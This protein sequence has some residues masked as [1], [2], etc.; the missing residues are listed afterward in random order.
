[1]KRT[2]LLFLVMVLLCLSP[3]ALANGW[4]LKGELLQLVSDTDD[5]NDYTT[6][7]DQA[8]NIAIMKSRYHHVLMMGEEGRLQTYTKA[9][10][11]PDS[12]NGAPLLTQNGATFSIRYH[13]HLWF[14]FAR[15][16][17]GV[18]HLHSAQS[19]EI[20]V[21]A[22]ESEYGYSAVDGNGTRARLVRRIR[23]EDFNIELFPRTINDVRHLNLMRDWLDSESPIN[24]PLEAEVTGAGEGTA[25]V[26]SAPFGKSAWRAA[27][28]K[29]AVGLGGRLWKMNP[30]RNAEGEE[31]W[32][33]RYDV[34]QRTQR[35]GYI[36]RRY[37]EAETWWE[38]KD[39][40][41]A[42]VEVIQ[43]TYLTDDPDV[44]QYRQF[45][46]PAGTQLTCLGLY[47]D[48]YAYVSAEAKDGRVVDGGQIVWGF[49][50]LRDIQ[51]MPAAR[52]MDVM[53]QLA[54]TWW[55]YAGGLQ[56]G[57]VITLNADGTYDSY[58]GVWDGELHG[59]H[60]SHGCWYVLE[61]NPSYGLYWNDP[62]YEI[63]FLRDDGSARVHGL[64]VDG[65]TFSL[66]FWEGGGGYERVK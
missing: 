56:E 6:L 8:G 35:I 42:A 9:V 33:I 47:N 31:Y 10:F 21:K 61:H 54:G 34:S 43:A 26:Y 5:W 25:P 22:T 63:V 58:L 29:A 65:D 3:A 39:Y 44:S 7:G 37:L 45:E 36:E 4:G 11:Q 64:T 46:L 51:M 66:T 41:H 18:Y 15:R 17:D 62:P 19:G 20:S 2:M 57:D 48:D 55:F 1:M 52:R 32:C 27:K 24:Y 53:A 28:G 49:V 16:E 38:E 14:T 50:P 59:E 13:D 23:L 30:V 12:F 40:L 60:L